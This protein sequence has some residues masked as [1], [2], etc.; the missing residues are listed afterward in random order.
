MII[1]STRIPT[2][3]T[4]RLAAY[5]AEPADNEASTWIRGCPGD[6]LLLGE[7]SRI[8]GKQYAVRHFVIAPNAAMNQRDFVW[9]FAEVCQEYGVSIT[10]GNRAAIVKHVKPRASGSG[11][12]VHWHVAIPEY[13]VETSKVLSSRFYK[14]RNERISRICELKLGHTVVP[15]RFNRQVYAALRKERP[16][17]DLTP[18]EA[19]LRSAAIEAGWPEDAWLEYKANSNSFQS[20][21]ELMR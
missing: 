10:S 9:V 15:G 21:L 3:H 2:K 16:T 20:A 13:D 18:F 19:S 7:I 17:I 6:L 12:E 14:M 1:K 8:A 11:N 5:L 4:K